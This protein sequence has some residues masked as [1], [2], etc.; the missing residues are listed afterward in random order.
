MQKVKKKV[1]IERSLI[2]YICMLTIPILQFCVFYIGVNLNSILLSFQNVSLDGTV[3]WTGENMA[4]AFENFF[5]PLSGLPD[6]LWR[7]V[8]TSLLTIAITTPLCLFFSNYIYKKMFFSTGFRILLFMPSIISGLVLT[9]TY[10]FFIERAIP[11][12]ARMITGEQIKGLIQNVDTRYGA[13]LFFYIWAGFGTNMLLYSN[14]MSAISPEIVDS[15]KIDG[16]TGLKE[17][18]HISFPIIWPTFTTCFVVTVS[19]I[20]TNQFGL[21][22]FYGASA[23]D[24]IQSLGYYLYKE[25]QTN[26]TDGNMGSYSYLSA[27][28][29]IITLIAV[30]LT[31][32]TKKLMEKFGPSVE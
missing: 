23:P 8:W 13:I 16:A 30:P 14:A 15:A 9:T 12:I 29:L 22:N 31:L 7:S 20:F 28:G 25:T 2:F 5:N 32:G 4:K 1:K 6:R 11:E 18:W 21:Y 19:G 27:L 3:V 26:T 10:Q 24:D 17:F